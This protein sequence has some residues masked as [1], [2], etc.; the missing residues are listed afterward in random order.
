MG[1]EAQYLFRPM[2]I[3]DIEQVCALE[4]ICFADPWSEKSMRDELEKNELAYYGVLVP[5]E[6]TTKGVAYGGFWAII[7]EGHITN[8]AV[9]PELRGRR[10]GQMLVMGL[11]E[12]AKM[13]NV[14]RMT[15][16]V[17]VSNQSAQ[18]L[19][20]RLGFETQG[21]RKK[22]YEDKEDALIMWCEL[23][24]EREDK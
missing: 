24:K 14:E 19:Y 10:L 5:A 3:L 4:K 20:E 12:I 2:T 1:D 23:N 13:R 8:I 21:I 17:R 6:D 16:E 22:Y 7:D 15:L 11:M 9:V 18:R